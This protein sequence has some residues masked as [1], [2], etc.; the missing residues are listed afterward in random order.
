MLNFP[1]G[2]TNQNIITELFTSVKTHNIPVIFFAGKNSDYRKLEAFDELVPFSISRPNSGEALFNLQIVASLDNPISNLTGINS[3]VQIFRNSA[4][5]Q[6]KPGAVT[7]A[8]DKFSGEPVMMTRTSG[9]YK[10][11]AFLGYGL[12]RW[13]LNSSSNAEKTL[14]SMLLETI[15]MTLQKEKK[16]K[17]RV[18]PEKDI[19]DYSQPVK[20][21]AEVFDENY[22][23]TRNAAV[24]GKITN[25]DGNKIADLEFSADENKYS[26]FAG[27]LLYGDY[28]IECETELNGG[29]YANDN[30]RFFVDTVNTEYLTT[31][32]NIDALN[33]L[34]QNTG[35]TIISKENWNELSSLINNTQNPNLTETSLTQS[36]RFNLWENKYYLAVIILL[37]SVEWIIRKRNNIP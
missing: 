4:G 28:K 36:V 23:T 2:Q 37:F 24:T 1:T 33:E 11:T 7:L 26:A 29:Y 20:I 12:W 9:N 27:P 35:G 32:T 5:I 13:K 10:S 3:T 34:S 31:K 17:F 18:Y 15:N 25:K 8:T 19:F 6:P 22:N 21:I 16:T 14:E 30:S